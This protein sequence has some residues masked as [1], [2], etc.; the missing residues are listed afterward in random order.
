MVS[1]VDYGLNGL[2]SCPGGGRCIVFFGK[3]FHSHSA[4]LHSATGV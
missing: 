1:V 2:G 3:I 4:S